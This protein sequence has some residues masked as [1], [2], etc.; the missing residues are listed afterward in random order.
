M[1]FI[2]LGA[3]NR[4]GIGC[5]WI[6]LVADMCICAGQILQ[7]DEEAQKHMPKVMQDQIGKSKPSGSGGNNPS[8]TRGF[9][10][11]AR[12]RQ[13]MQQQQPPQQPPQQGG[14][15]GEGADPSAALVANM[16]SNI[17]ESAENLHGLKFGKPEAL[18]RSEN[19]RARYDLV[20]AKF[21][22]LIMRHGK[23]AQAQRVT[24]PQPVH[25]IVHG[26]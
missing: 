13:D 24:H 20:L 7:R 1:Y 9:A 25:E 6:G 4:I 19:H 15:A 5:V 11:S 16:I 26:G 2:Q 21:T 23:K 22:N 3:V 17:T 18:P 14:G 8:G 10:T 12:V